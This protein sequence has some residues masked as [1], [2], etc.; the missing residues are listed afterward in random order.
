MRI[1]P[2]SML[3]AAFSSPFTMFVYEMQTPAKPNIMQ[4]VKIKDIRKQ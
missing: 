4:D 1:T 3:T 2:P